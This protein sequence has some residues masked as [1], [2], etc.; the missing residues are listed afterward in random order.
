MQVSDD[1]T[2]LSRVSAHELEP[3][4]R[5][6]ADLC[7]ALSSP[8]R[9]AILHMLCE[10]ERCVTELASAMQISMQNVSQHLRLLKERKL[11]RSRKEG[12]TVYYSITNP[13]FIEACNLIRQALIE[14]HQ[15]EGRF[16]L[17]AELLA[18]A[19]PTPP[20]PFST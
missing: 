14:Q 12:Q 2:T 18:A 8:H 10:R 4:F 3:L 6:H 9:L 15:A 17:A 19:Q 7:K 5:L 13:K 20:T 11:V 1:A 16:F